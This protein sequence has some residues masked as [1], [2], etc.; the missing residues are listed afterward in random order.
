MVETGGGETKLVSRSICWKVQYEM[1]RR[2]SAQDRVLKW[3]HCG[4]E[5]CGE[6]VGVGSQV[7]GFADVKFEMP[8]RHSGRAVR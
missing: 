3:D 1:K 2:V 6:C 7:L 8:H 5:R 4:R